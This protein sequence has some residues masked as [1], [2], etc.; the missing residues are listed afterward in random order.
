MKNDNLNFGVEYPFND[1]SISDCV[2]SPVDFSFF[3]R[4]NT[5]LV[6]QASSSQLLGRSPT[7]SKSGPKC[8][9]FGLGRK[10]SCMTC[11]ICIQLNNSSNA[12][13]YQDTVMSVTV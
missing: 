5:V 13:S 2:T 7:V 9:F 3:L 10:F 6:D 11:M 8:I 1:L 12:F 4:N